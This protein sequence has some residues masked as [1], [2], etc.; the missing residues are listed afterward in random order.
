MTGTI[1]LAAFRPPWLFGFTFPVQFK[2]R[3]AEE[4][5]QIGNYTLRRQGI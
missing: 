5:G 4:S 2:F 3:V 1:Y